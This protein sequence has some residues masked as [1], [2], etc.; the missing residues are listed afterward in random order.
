MCP[1]PRD[2]PDP[3]IEPWSP[4]SPAGREILYHQSHAG[5]PLEA[6]IWIRLLSV[7]WPPILTLMLTRIRKGIYY[8]PHFVGKRT[9]V[10]E[11]KL[12]HKNTHVQGAKWDIDPSPGHKHTALYSIHASREYWW[13]I[14]CQMLCQGLRRQS[15]WVRGFVWEEGMSPA[16]Q[17]GAGAWPTLTLTAPRSAEVAGKGIL[18]TR[19]GVV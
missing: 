19:T 14:T 4:V 9:E 7:L 5:S 18:E 2:L 6:H 17:G 13:H 10:W 1:S 11:M 16:L 3:G 12:S 15:F 8:H